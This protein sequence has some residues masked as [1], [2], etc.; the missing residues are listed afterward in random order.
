MN[1]TDS[2]AL[3]SAYVDGETS[4]LEAHSV[5]AHLRH[6]PACTAKHESLVALRAR[7]HAETARFTAPPSLGA[8][9][10]AALDATPVARPARS[11]R[12]WGWTAG[13]D[14]RWRWMTGGALAGC[15]A[16]MLAWF[17]G[18]TVVAWRTSEDVAVE[19]VT[20]HVRSTL[21]NQLIQVA[22]SNQHTVKPWLSARLDYSPPVPD[23][24]AD[25]FT[26]VGGRVDYIDRRPIATLVY[27]VRD[28]MIDVY[29]CPSTTRLAPGALRTVRGF[30]VAYA[31]G[32]GMDWLAVSDVNASELEAFVRKLAQDGAPR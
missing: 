2:E 11:D 30:H 7:I 19:A 31:Q 1:C 25:G 22:S 13:G 9:V 21:G 8:R 20:S 14:G 5:R 12:R 29:V 4:R 26:L 23:L 27:R 16:T 18:T 32:T 3:I 28:H 10:L 15:A 6:C 17:V 24:S